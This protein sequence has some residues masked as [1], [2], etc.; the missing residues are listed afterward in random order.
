MSSI[1]IHK[2]Y[3][4]DSHKSVSRRLSKRHLIQLVFN[5]PLVVHI[6]KETQSKPTQIPHHIKTHTY[7]NFQQVW[8][9]NLFLLLLFVCLFFKKAPRASDL[10]FNCHCE[11]IWT[12]S[13]IGTS[14]YIQMLEIQIYLKNHVSGTSQAQETD[15]QKGTCS[16]WGSRLGSALVRL[17]S[18]S[19]SSSSSLIKQQAL[20]HAKKSLQSLLLF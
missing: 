8:F 5:N 7:Q 4:S 10:Q 12:W 9:G 15:Y 6:Y 1:N 18:S 19:G 11:L 20:S 2:L 3:T 16:V 17:R 13:R 14:G